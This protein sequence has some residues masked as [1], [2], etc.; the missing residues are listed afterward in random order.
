MVSP[1]WGVRRPFSSAVWIM[2]RAT[3]SL[4]L[5]PAPLRNS[6]LARMSQPVTSERDFILTRGVLPMVDSMPMGME[7]IVAAIDCRFVWSSSITGNVLLLLVPKSR[8][9]EAWARRRR[10]QRLRSG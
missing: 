3:R 8:E 1:L 9:E 5:L 4:G 6:A 7:G 2:C 10:C